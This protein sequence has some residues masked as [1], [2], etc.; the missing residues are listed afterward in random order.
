MTI[1]IESLRIGSH[2][3]LCGHRWRVTSIDAMDGVI[4]VERTITNNEG[5]ERTIGRTVNEADPIP[6]SDELLTE[7]GFKAI[8]HVGMGHWF[9]GNFDLIKR[10]DSRYWEHDGG[11]YLEYLHELEDLYWLKYSSELIKD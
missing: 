7:L 11:I 3:R 10:K 4:G 6:L 5:T 8:E 2:V 1:E 9:L